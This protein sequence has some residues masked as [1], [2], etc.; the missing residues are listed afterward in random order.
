M[1]F[2]RLVCM[3]VVGSIL[4]GCTSNALKLPTESTDKELLP[5]VYSGAPKTATGAT[6]LKVVGNDDYLHN[7]KIQYSTAQPRLLR[8]VLVEALDGIE[9]VPRD[10][11]VDLDKEVMVRATNMSGYDFLDYLEAQTG[12]DIVWEEGVV[13]IHSFT[14]K[15][16][17][18]ASFAAPRGVDNKSVQVQSGPDEEGSGSS[19]GSSGDGGDRQSKNSVE[20]KIGDDEWQMMLVGAKE[21]LGVNRDDDDEDERDRD[22]MSPRE[23]RDMALRTSGR[24]EVDEEAKQFEPFVYGIRSVGLVMAGGTPFQM[25]MLDEYFKEAQAMSSVIFD[26]QMQTYDV[27]LNHSKEKGIEWDV[28]TQDM[29]AKT[30]YSFGLSQTIS[31]IVDYDRSVWESVGAV[32]SGDG[33]TGAAFFLRFLES[34]GEVELKEQPH[35]TVRHGVPAQLYSG[36]EIT[37]ISDTEQSQDINGNPTVTYDLTRRKIGVT[38]SVTARKLEDDRIL[39]DLWP[40]VSAQSGEDRFVLN[41]TEFSTPRIALKEFSTQVITRSGVPVHLGGLITKKLAN[42]LE[43]LPVK[44]KLTERIANALLDDIANQIERR[45]IVWVVTP[46]I[47]EKGVRL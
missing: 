40:V 30:P 25:K 43:G 18:L 39:L 11:R 17:Q 46:T 35:L 44:S 36:E 34:Y 6:F 13:Y 21:I 23:R 8:H 1:E 10:S 5:R 37:Y 27:T 47:V 38:L 12:Y 19:G 42:H 16:W 20:L 29:A 2:K 7:V 28:L 15:Q 45:E 22:D 32:T 9:I 31:D 14:R 4:G 24:L 33:D 26:I 41:G 3:A